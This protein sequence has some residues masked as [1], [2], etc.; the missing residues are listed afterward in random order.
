MIWVFGGGFSF[1]AGSYKQIHGDNLVNKRVIFV[2]FNYRV[3]PLGFLP[4][5]DKASGGLNGFADAIMAVKF[6]HSNIANFGGD[7][8]RITVS[9][10]S[11]GA[12]TTCMLSASPFTVG[13]INSVIIHSGACTGSIYQPNSPKDGAKRLK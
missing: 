6:V 13:L 3:G 2:S 5:D 8:F 11:A 12:I 7:N 10:L 4:R 1:G 9:G